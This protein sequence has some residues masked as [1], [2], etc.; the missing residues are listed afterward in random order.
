MVIIGGRICAGKDPIK[1]TQSYICWYAEEA[2]EQMIKYH[3]PASVTLAQ[4]IFESKCGNSTLAKKSNNHF[5]IK[6]H[7]A[8]VGDTVIKTDDTLNECFR[9]YSSVEDS[10]TDHSLFLQSRN[11]YQ[12]LFKLSVTDYKGWCRGLKAAGYATFS[13]YADE[14]I[15]IIEENKL[16]LFDR[17]E[18]VTNL[19]KTIPIE[20][21]RKSK[22]TLNDFT[23]K[24]LAKTGSLFISEKRFDM[25]LLSLIIDTP[26]ISNY[27]AEK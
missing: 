26:D 7:T 17:Y 25:K 24:D 10:Y 12:H 9:K 8:W 15:K 16:Y 19:S 27:V 2:V 1:V 23:L 14:L 3:I 5:G 6:C 22:L 4:A 18:R 21:I 13:G 11:R 20:K